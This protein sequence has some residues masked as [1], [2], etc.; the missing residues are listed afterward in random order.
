MRNTNKIQP[1]FI[2]ETNTNRPSI[3]SICYQTSRS[4]TQAF[5]IG[6]T[7]CGKTSHYFR[8]ADIEVVRYTRQKQKAVE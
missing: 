2:I 5:P 1:V 7:R 3:K 6:F 4:Q 8:I